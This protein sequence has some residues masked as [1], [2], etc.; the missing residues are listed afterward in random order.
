MLSENARF[1]RIATGAFDFAL[2]VAVVLA[3]FYFY[4]TH[5]A[6][7]AASLRPHPA[8]GQ[9]LPL[10]V[11]W[12][13]SPKTLVIVMQKD[14]HF[15]TA[16]APFYRKLRSIETTSNAFSMIAALPQEQFVAQGYLSELGL[17]VDETV[18][19]S[20]ASLSVGGTPTLLLVDRSGRVINVWVG[21]LQ[22]EKQEAEVL[23][24]ISG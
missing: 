21:Q 15:C 20:L 14:C 2:V 4:R 17:S 22:T 19:T 9:V 1:R 11:N 5:A 7:P 6:R 18:K 3:G 12:S 24:A 8:I 16:S 13:K 10:A 23:K